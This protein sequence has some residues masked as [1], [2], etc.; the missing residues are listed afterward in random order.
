MSDAFL[1]FP[2]TPDRDSRP[3]WDAL[4]AGEFRL[5]RCSACGALRW[6]AREICNRCR[7]FDARW[8][9][10]DGAGTVAS[11]V[12]T[13]QAF[14]PALREAVPYTVVQVRL[15]AQDDLL[16]IGGWLGAREPVSGEAVALEIVPGKD[17][18]HLPCWRPAGPDAEQA[19]A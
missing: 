17:G 3:W 16:L 15:D 6:P 11:W 10:L 14:A 8:E 4:A 18:F 2:P 13:H 12:R 1:P 9:T 19:R 7:S 5:Q